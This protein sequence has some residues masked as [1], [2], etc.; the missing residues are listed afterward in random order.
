M[1]SRFA[2][3]VWCSRRTTCWIP[4]SGKRSGAHGNGRHGEKAATDFT[5]THCLP[6]NIHGRQLFGESSS[7]GAPKGSYED[8]RESLGWIHSRRAALSAAQ[9][10]C[11]Q[12]LVC[13]AFIV[14]E[15]SRFFLRPEKCHAGKAVRIVTT[16]R[17]NP[18]GSGT[19]GIPSSL[20]AW[21]SRA[22]LAMVKRQTDAPCVKDRI[23]GPPGH[24]P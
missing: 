19:S 18:P 22:V 4:R 16:V 1:S 7:G 12:V 9:P 17:R 23:D 6:A 11:F 13:F 3:N 8:A 21:P 15:R 5:A 14:A 10:P 24:M 2:T 20:C